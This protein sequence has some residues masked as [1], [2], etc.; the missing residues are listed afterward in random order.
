M[1]RPLFRIVPLLAMA[2]LTAACASSRPRPAA[3]PTSGI[4]CETGRPVLVVRNDS[5]R[6]VEIVESRIGS[7]GRTVIALVPSGRHE[8][9]IRNEF[10]YG[11]VAQFAQTDQVVA[12]ATLAHRSREVTL[13]R[14]CAAD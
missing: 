9:A 10:G 14:T 2:A 1:H 11:Y 6:E 4:R 3:E 7:G 12:G 5:G 13:E 8:V